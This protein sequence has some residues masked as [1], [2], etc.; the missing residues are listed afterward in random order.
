M[1]KH[2]EPPP[3]FQQEMRGLRGRALLNDMQARRAPGFRA[4]LHLHDVITV[5]VF[6]P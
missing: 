4:I 2:G 6:V 1:I 5:T 3:H